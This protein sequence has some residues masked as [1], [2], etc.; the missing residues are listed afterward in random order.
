MPWDH[1]MP[2]FQP[3]FRVFSTLLGGKFWVLWLSCHPP[4]PYIIYIPSSDLSLLL[5]LYYF[6]SRN[7][8][9]LM[10]W[11]FCSLQFSSPF[12]CW[13][14]CF[15][16]FPSHYYTSHSSVFSPCT[17]ALYCTYNWF[18]FHHFFLG[19]LWYLLNIFTF[20]V[21]CFQKSYIM[22]SCIFAGTQAKLLQ[23]LLNLAQPL[24]TKT[25]PCSCYLG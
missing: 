20:P 7:L 19:S 9:G 16:R 24:R 10:D 25:W 11:C 22:Q 6:F 13:F 15:T 21:C 18:C 5:F 3:V 12:F 23:I 8:I 17:W 4:H 14:C 2:A 1:F